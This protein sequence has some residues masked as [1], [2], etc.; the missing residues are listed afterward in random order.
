MRFRGPALLLLFFLVLSLTGAG[1]TEIDTLPAFSEEQ[2]GTTAPQTPGSAEAAV[3]TTPPAARETTATE[4]IEIPKLRFTAVGDIMPGRRVGKKLEAEGGYP[5]AFSSVKGILKQGDIVFANLEAPLTAS[6]H[7]LSKE[8]KIVLKASP[9]AIE[10]I[11]TGG[12]NLISLSNNHIMDYYDTGLFDT[13]SLLD[14]NGIAHAGAGKNLEEAGRPAVIEK[15][16]YKIGLLCYTD[17]AKYIYDGQPRISFEAGPDKAGVVPRDYEVIRQAVAQLRPRVDLLAVSLHWGVEESFTITP[18]QVD[19][20]RKLLD[21][22]ADMILGHHPHQFQ[23]IE[24]YKG[25][26]IIY[27]MGNFL[28]DQND[29]EN[30]E[31]FIVEMEYEGGTLKSLTAKPVRI[32]DKSRVELQSGE[33]AFNILEREAGLCEKLGTVADIVDDTLVFRLDGQ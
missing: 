6:S 7:G 25:K 24:L 13:I 31:S 27:S 9:D 12:F 11:K 26:P 8:K 30:M 21:D 28:F 15:N 16:G 4:A 14:E 29:P 10:A 20:A 17:M 22:G 18:E 33:A 5:S 19:F 23:G 3:E 2:P 1:A 32:A